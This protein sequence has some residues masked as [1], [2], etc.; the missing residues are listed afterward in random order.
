MINLSKTLAVLLLLS[1]PVRAEKRSP[2]AGSVVR[3]REYVVR[4]T[5]HKIEEFIG[6]VYYRGGDR[7]LRSDR[8]RFDHQSQ[9][10]HGRGHVT[11]ILRR[12]NGSVIEVRGDE[13]E[14]NVRT[15]KGWLNEKNPDH[16]IEYSYERGGQRD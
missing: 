4:R 6:D 9:V 2:L 16:P 8:A 15:G 12:K 1:A 7:E 14:H 10:W 5:P 3:S 13:L 11:G